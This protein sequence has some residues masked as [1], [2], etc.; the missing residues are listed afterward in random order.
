MIPTM[1]SNIP[2]RLFV[3]NYLC[4]EHSH[5][6]FYVPGS[7]KPKPCVNSFNPPKPV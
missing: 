7:G 5:G 3:I 6:I 1:P 2:I 4:I